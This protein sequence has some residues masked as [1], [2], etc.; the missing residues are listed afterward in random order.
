MKT[1]DRLGK[2]MHNTLK[3]GSMYMQDGTLHST[4]DNNMYR[5]MKVP[6][7]QVDNMFD[8]REPTR[9]E[10]KIVADIA[11]GGFHRDYHSSEEYGR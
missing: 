3:S 9:Y 1:V 4:E 11:R 7:N 5:Y 8:G 10:A 2:E 6:P